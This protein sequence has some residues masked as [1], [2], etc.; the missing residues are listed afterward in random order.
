[1]KMLGMALIVLGVL[2][3]AYQGFTYTTRE[4]VID[5]GPTYTAD[6]TG[7]ATASDRYAIQAALVPW[8]AYTYTTTGGGAAQEDYDATISVYW[9]K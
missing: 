6:D 3:L 5:I 2:A 9:S 8:L 4:T 7:S 1:M